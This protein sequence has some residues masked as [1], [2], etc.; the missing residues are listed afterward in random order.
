MIVKMVKTEW[1]QDYKLPSMFIAANQC[2][3]KCE[4]DCGLRVCQNNNL[5]KINSIDISIRSIIESYLDNPITSAIIWG[6]LEPFEQFN[7]LVSFIKILRWNYMCDDFVIVYTG[8]NKDEILPQIAELSYYK[9]IIVKFGRFVPNQKKHYDDILGVYL[10][11]P[12]QY[13]EIIN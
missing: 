11:S 13:A 4:R 8:F 10:A 6:G 3:W 2:N 7:D 1:Y 5:A 9:N 12:N